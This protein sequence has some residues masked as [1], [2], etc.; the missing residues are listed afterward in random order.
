[1]SCAAHVVQAFNKLGCS[2]K[3]AVPGQRLAIVLYL[4]KHEKFSNKLHKI[5]GLDGTLLVDL[6]GGKLVRTACPG[7][8]ASTLLQEALQDEPAYAAE[9]KFCAPTSSK[10]AECLTSKGRWAPDNLRLT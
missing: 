4:P 2:L 1:M 3:N 7:V 5:I 8:P 9:F 10:L 6:V